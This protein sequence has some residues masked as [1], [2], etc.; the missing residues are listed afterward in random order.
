VFKPT[1]SS[2]IVG[3]GVEPFMGLSSLREF[4]LP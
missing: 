4:W 1:C 3:V 2:S